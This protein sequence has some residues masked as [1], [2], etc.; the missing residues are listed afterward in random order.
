METKQHPT[1]TRQAHSY[2]YTP[3]LTHTDTHEH[4]LYKQASVSMQSIPFPIR[5]FSRFLLFSGN[6]ILQVPIWMLFCLESNC[7]NYF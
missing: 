5:L 3:T 6:F 7:I 1:L 2:T 4:I